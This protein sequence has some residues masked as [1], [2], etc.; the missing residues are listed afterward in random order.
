M[1]DVGHG[2]RISLAVAGG[3]ALVLFV[4]SLLLPESP[5]SLAER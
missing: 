4:G 5:N 3:P 2:W 1:Q